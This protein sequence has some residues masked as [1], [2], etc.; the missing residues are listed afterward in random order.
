MNITEITSIAIF[1]F[2]FCACQSFLNCRKG[3]P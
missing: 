1:S 2:W 3:Y